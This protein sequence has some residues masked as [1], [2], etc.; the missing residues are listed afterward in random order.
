MIEN[1]AQRIDNLASRYVDGF[2]QAVYAESAYWIAEEADQ[3]IAKLKGLLK[4]VLTTLETRVG[5]PLKLANRVDE[6]LE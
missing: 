4:E 6:A 3:E 5:C 1:Y 2:G